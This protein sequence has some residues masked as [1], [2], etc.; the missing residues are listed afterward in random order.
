M[1]SRRKTQEEADATYKTYDQWASNLVGD[2][3]NGKNG[4]AE[5][6]AIASL[7][8]LAESNV[9]PLS[10]AYAPIRRERGR[11]TGHSPVTAG[12]GSRTKPNETRRVMSKLPKRA[13]DTLQS[14][15]VSIIHHP[16][17]TKEQ[18]QVLAQKCGLSYQQISNWFTNIRKREWKPAVDNIMAEH[19]NTGKPIA[20]EEATKFLQVNWAGAEG[21][22]MQP[23]VG[24]AHLGFL[25]P[26]GA[27]SLDSDEP[28]AIL[29]P[30]ADDNL[31]VSDDLAASDQYSDEGE[32]EEE[33]S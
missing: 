15:F 24:A 20:R 30:T 14:Y 26:G 23:I 29:P 16:Y 8:S 33:S 32:D 7:A 18:R 17:P 9:D 13:A 27:P 3:I 10:G 31:A 5:H 12:K 2:A 6:N 19:A 11:A 21:K 22:R 1:A 4:I 28:I 25:L